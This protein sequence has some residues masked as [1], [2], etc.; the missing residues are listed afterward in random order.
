MDVANDRRRGCRGDAGV[1]D[2]HFMYVGDADDQRND[3][4]Q[5][6]PSTQIMSK[7]YQQMHIE[8]LIKEGKGEG[9]E[10]GMVCVGI[11]KGRCCDGGWADLL[12][13]EDQIKFGRQSRLYKYEGTDTA[14]AVFI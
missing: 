12:I 13:A 11:N 6:K 10:M 7:V 3:K 9:K 14:W 5:Q 8:S 1:V 4:Q 2:Y